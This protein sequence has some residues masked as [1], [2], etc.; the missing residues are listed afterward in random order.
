[1]AYKQI[2]NQYDVLLQLFAQDQ[3]IRSDQS[4]QYLHDHEPDPTD[5]SCKSMYE[6]YSDD[7]CYLE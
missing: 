3:A 5:V 6:D 7:I 1:M 2:T 4:M